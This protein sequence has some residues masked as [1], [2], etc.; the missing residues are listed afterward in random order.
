[1]GHMH[2]TILKCGSFSV[3]V[4]GA[5]Q[6]CF[7]LVICCLTDPCRSSTYQRFGHR[8][9]TVSE[10]GNV[11]QLRNC[12]LRGA[13][14]CRRASGKR[15]VARGP[16]L[17]VDCHDV[18]TT[19]G[20]GRCPGLRSWLGDPRPMAEAETVWCQESCPEGKGLHLCTSTAPLS[21][22]MFPPCKRQA[23]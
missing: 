12:S 9:S 8:L 19:T 1:M 23:L 7:W 13:A 10:A 18:C 15:G 2:L 3:R 16:C 21:P 14:L 11:R 6:A 17:C 20:W 4:A 5:D 22:P